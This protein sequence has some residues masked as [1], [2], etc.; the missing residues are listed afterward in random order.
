MLNGADDV[1]DGGRLVPKQE[2]HV[3]V[4]DGPGKTSHHHEESP[5][6]VE[7]RSLRG[8]EGGLV[9]GAIVVAVKLLPDSVDFPPREPKIFLPCVI[10]SGREVDR[11]LLAEPRR[12]TTADRGLPM[13][14]DQNTRS[15]ERKAKRTSQTSSRQTRPRL[16]P[17]ED[18]A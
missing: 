1:R 10:R 11:K 9:G 18:Q 16:R 2:F 14:I 17:R 6:R 13:L 4:A 12:E 8:L 15:W 7:A 5:C 3:N